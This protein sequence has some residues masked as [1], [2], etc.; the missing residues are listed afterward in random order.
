MISI[1]PYDGRWPEQFASEANQLRAAMGSL[2]L[3]IEHVGST[4]IPGLAA[5][6]VI[7]IQISVATLDGL[8]VYVAPL[9]SLGYS[10]IPYG[11]VDLVYPFFRKPAE[12]PSTHHLHL[13]VAGTEHERRHLAFRDYLRTHPKVANEYV[14]LKRS[15]AATHVGATA[16]SRERY[17]LAKTD[18]VTSIERQALSEYPLSGGRR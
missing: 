6:P 11:A 14:A 10:H 4:S 1:V 17:S 9:A 15:L 8:D 5:K 2:S 13:C 12:W 16:E 7:D 3:R 18:F